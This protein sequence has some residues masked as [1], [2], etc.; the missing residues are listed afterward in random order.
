MKNLSKILKH[1]KAMTLLYVE[2]NSEVRDN[3]LLVFE[4]LFGDIILGVDGED[5]IQKFYEKK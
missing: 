2:D 1:T 5:G 4:D 3:T